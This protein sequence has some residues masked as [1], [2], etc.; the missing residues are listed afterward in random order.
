VAAFSGAG[1]SAESGLSTFR[2]PD[3]DALWSRFDPT[4]LASVAGF[5]ANPERVID[6]N[7]GSAGEIAD[8]C[9]ARKAGK[10]LPLLLDG[11]D[12][13]SAA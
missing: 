3:P 13:T 2:D 4:E 12:L 5:E 1:L 9:L 11:F 6:P 10:V 8:L 7:P